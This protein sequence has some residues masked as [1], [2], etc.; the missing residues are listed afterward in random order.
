M[1]LRRIRLDLDQ[2]TRDKEQE[3][4][5]LDEDTRRIRTGSAPRVTSGLRNAEIGFQRLQEVTTIAAAPRRR[6]Q[7]R[8]AGRGRLVG[9]GTHHL[10]R[11]TGKPPV[12]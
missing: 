11:K 2:P 1:T 6:R 5:T 8:K 9:P 10:E 4:L 3:L 12:A 7:P